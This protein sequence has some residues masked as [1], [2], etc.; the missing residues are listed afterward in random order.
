MGA[1]R[2]KVL[3]L[4]RIRTNGLPSLLLSYA[5]SEIAKYSRGDAD[6][7]VILQGEHFVAV[8]PFWASWPFETMIIPYKSALPSQ[9]FIFWGP[10]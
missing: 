9:V 2:L 10:C 7:R 8:V 5:T 3:T 1:L 6:N 4:G